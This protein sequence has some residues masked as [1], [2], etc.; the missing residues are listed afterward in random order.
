MKQFLNRIAS[1]LLKNMSE[2]LVNIACL[3]EMG[4][5]PTEANTLFGAVQPS[6]EEIG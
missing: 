4:M 2:T 1:H 3:H 5:S 6:Y